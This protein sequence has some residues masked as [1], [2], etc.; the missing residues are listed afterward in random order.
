MTTREEYL[1]Y[2]EDKLAWLSR[3]VENKNSQQ[4]YDM[5]LATET[6]VA[7][8]LNLVY[9]YR[10]KNANVLKVNMPAIDLFDSEN[11]IV[12]QVTSD[13]SL[14]KMGQSFFSWD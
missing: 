1:D 3:Y 10:L 6:I 7:G 2:I 8:L 4:R 9:G 12:I 14:R 5:N 13:T 11:R